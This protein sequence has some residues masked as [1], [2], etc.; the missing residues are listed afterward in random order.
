MVFFSHK[1]LTESFGQTKIFVELSTNLI[2]SPSSLL[3]I[4]NKSLFDNFGLRG[5]QDKIK[6]L[7]YYRL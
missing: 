5:L 2:K 6:K 1:I 4:Q 3:N 7:V